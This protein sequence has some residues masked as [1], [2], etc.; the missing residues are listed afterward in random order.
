MENMYP[1]EIRTAVIDYKKV[2][3]YEPDYYARK[4]MKWRW[5]IYP[6]AVVEDVSGFLQQME[7]LPDS[8]EELQERIFQDYGI[9]VPQKTLQDI[10]ILNER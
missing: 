2:S 5:I 1:E 10:L 7:S 9:R 4:M 3:S 6:W 8:I